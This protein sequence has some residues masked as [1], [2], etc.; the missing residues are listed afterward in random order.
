MSMIHG[1]K[2]CKAGCKD[3]LCSFK[4]KGRSMGSDG[5]FQMKSFEPKHLCGW[6]DK[7]TKVIAMWLADKYLKHYR[8]DP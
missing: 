1:R 4:A 7:N 2:M 8:D 5:T 3:E 6:K